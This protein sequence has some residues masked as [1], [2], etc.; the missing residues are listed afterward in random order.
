[1]NTIAWIA[2]SIGVAALIGGITNHL[3]IKMLFHPRNPVMVFGRKLPF[4]PGIIPKRKEEIAH[5]LGQ[6]V[7]DYLVT[8]EG[9]AGLLRK[10]SFQVRIEA[11]LR[12]MLQQ[13]AQDD[14]SLRE[15]LSDIFGE[16]EAARLLAQAETIVADGS[17]RLVRWL[18]EEKGLLQRPFE[19]WLPGDKAARA[20][21]WSSRLADLLVKELSRQLLSPSGAQLIRSLADK[22]MDQAGG[23]LGMLAGMFMD[24]ERMVQKVQPIVLESLHSQEVRTALRHFIRQQWDR[25]E[26]KSPEDAIRYFAEG[27]PL[28]IVQGWVRKKLP[29]Q[30]WVGEAAERSVAAWLAPV[31]PKI[32]EKL[33]HVVEQVLALSASRMDTIVRAL[34]LPALVGQQVKNF[35]VEHLE[36]IVLAV[37]GKEFRAITWLGAGLGGMIGLVQAIVYTIWR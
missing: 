27:E 26:M 16:D 5:S 33:P 28:E 1:M 30:R 3:A 21:E 36:R 7:G 2:I 24:S 8:S 14:R 25:L 19:D 15:A 35:P 31:L 18:V 17:D 32:E 37:S 23:V 20:E 29:W 10:R 12:G 11:K 34:D 6:V 22:L 9:L 13:W 4:T